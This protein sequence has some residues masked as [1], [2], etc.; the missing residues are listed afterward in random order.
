M[1]MLS[2]VRPLSEKLYRGEV[3]WSG[4]GSFYAIL[5]SVS[6]IHFLRVVSC[7]LRTFKKKKKKKKKFVVVSQ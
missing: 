1:C 5:M 2:Q 7:V 3:Y 6:N 4:P